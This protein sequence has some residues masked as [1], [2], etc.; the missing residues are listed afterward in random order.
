M[1][2]VAFVLPASIEGGPQC[3][4][5]LHPTREHVERR[6]QAFRDAHHGE[7]VGGQRLDALRCIRRRLLLPFRL[8]AKDSSLFLAEQ[9]S[10]ECRPRS[11]QYAASPRSRLVCNH[12]LGVPSV[13]PV[14]LDG[15]SNPQIPH[16]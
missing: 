3:R 12:D 16:L 6:A 15:S 5:L 9:V 7:A 1:Q 13:A 4:P 2:S 14:P 11:T 8:F 10:D